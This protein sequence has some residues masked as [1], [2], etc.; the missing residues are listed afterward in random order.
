M[1]L[2][3][4]GIFT[5][6]FDKAGKI[7]PRLDDAERRMRDSC[8]WFLE[9]YHYIHRQSM[10][11][12]IRREGVKV[13]LDSGAFSAFSQ[14]VQ[15]D[16]NKYCH[17]IKTNSDIVDFASVLDAIGDYRGTWRNQ[18][19]IEKNGV[20]VLPCYHYG[21]PM[22]VLEYY[23]ENYRHFTIGGL[24]PVSTPQMKIWLDR[25][26]ERVLTDDNGVPKAR[27]HG[28]GVTSLPM[29]LRYPWDS[30]DSST[31]VQWAANGMILLPESGKQI[32]ISNQSSRR[33]QAWQHIDSLPQLQRQAIEDEIAR[34]GADP[35]RL[36][37]FYYSR[38]AWNAWAFPEYVKRRGGG[39]K[40]FEM[41]VAELF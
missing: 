13:F 35:D 22:E 25:I 30:V 14:G 23:V 26:W 1:K 41:E 29:M 38:W 5:S 32:D 31:W 24:V 12:K 20:A 28:F 7:Y 8:E 33:K 40:T 4:A 17:Y 18:A 34:T 19:A 16:L 3:L 36:R 21:E 39:R 9:S 10:V 6:N 37:Q 15:I 11:D 27:I 2:Y